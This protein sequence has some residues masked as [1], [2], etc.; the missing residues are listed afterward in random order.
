MEV[1]AEILPLILECVNYLN[2][3]VPLVDLFWWRCIIIFNDMEYILTI[4]HSWNG[5]LLGYDIILATQ[6][7]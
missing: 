7:V 5:R 4:W 3:L 2:N 6:D 1:S